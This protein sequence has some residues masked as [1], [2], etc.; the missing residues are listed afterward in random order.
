M[1]LDH[2]QSLNFQEFITADGDQLTTDSLKVAVVHG[3][4]H[5]DVLRLI[6]QRVI[7][8]GGWGV[9]NFAHT[10]YVNPQNGETYDMFTMTQAGYQFLVGKMTG[11]KAVQHQIAYIEAFGAMASYIKNQREG[12]RYRCALKELEV[13]DSEKRGSL[14]GRGLNQRRLEKPVLESEL[15]LLQALVQPSLLQ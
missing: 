15:A 13:K 8:A 2:I 5:R 10:P 9:R 4:N 7:E 3:K 6:R 1:A 14:H 11:K 12:L